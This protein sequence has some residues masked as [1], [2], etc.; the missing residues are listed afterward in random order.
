MGDSTTAYLDNREFLQALAVLERERPTDEEVRRFRQLKLAAWG[1]LAASPT[2]FVLVLFWPRL[3]YPLLLT[4]LF[5]LLLTIPL[6]LANLRLVRKLWRAATIRRRLRLSERLEASFHAWRRRNR[7]YN[8]LTFAM[9]VAG[10]PIFAGGLT[11]LSVSEDVF[12]AGAAVAVVVFGATCMFIHFIRRGTERFEVVAELRESLLASRDAQ[13]GTAGVPVEEY[14]QYVAL[15]RRQIARD[16][17]RSLAK[18]RRLPSQS[19]A[20]RMSR[21][22][23]EATAVLNTGDLTSVSKRIQELVNEPQPPS[24][25]AATGSG[26]TV[27][28]V[29]NT[30]LEIGFVVDHEH[31][32]VRVLSL[33]SVPRAATDDPA[34]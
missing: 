24:T 6:F 2:W 14:D 8:R 18:A 10:V 11:V 5:C 32:E 25:G 30:S 20:L 27:V 15:E 19:Y 23:R 13:T 29:E 7:F 17:K 22:A 31:R 33:G 26:V 12:A 34:R 28:P 21:G 9:S 3:A 4:A 1:V 16:R